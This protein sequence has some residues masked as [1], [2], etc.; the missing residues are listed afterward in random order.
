VYHSV[1][2]WKLIPC[3]PFLLDQSNKNSEQYTVRSSTNSSSSRSRAWTELKLKHLLVSNS[4]HTQLPCC[5]HKFNF[6]HHFIHFHV[7]HKI[8]TYEAQFLVG[9]AA[10]SQVHA[11]YTFC[12]LVHSSKLG[13]LCPELQLDTIA[14]YSSS[15]DLG[16][17]GH[18]LP[19][20][21][22]LI[23][24]AANKNISTTNS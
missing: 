5:T 6:T 3:Y 21:G 4:F 14:P 24:P 13:Q 17:W 8:I 10:F 16:T 22:L 11:F 20:P 7:V 18:H 12:T 9:I 2:C 15:T 19:A 1:L 23:L